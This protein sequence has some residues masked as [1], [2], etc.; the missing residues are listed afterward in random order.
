MSDGRPST[1]RRR[2]PP[3]PRYLRNV[4]VAVGASTRARA[5]LGGASA[6]GE[7]VRAHCARRRSPR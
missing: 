4:A 2:A 3:H 7:A 1:T 5:E 6:L